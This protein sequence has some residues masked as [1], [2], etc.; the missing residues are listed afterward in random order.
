MLLSL[1][2]QLLTSLG[3]ILDRFFGQASF[4]AHYRAY[5]VNQPE[6]QKVLS[7]EAARPY[8]HLL[9]SVLIMPVQVCVEGHLEAY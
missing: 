1:D 2:R 9:D 4:S 6:Q 3:A 5:I 8:R 7:T